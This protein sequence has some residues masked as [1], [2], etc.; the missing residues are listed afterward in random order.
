[1]GSQLACFAPIQLY[2]FDIT[3]KCKDLSHPQ[4]VLILPQW[5]LF[6]K[7]PFAFVNR[8]LTSWSVAPSI[9][10]ALPKRRVLVILLIILYL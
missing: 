2:P 7:V 5:A 10:T 6:Y 4:Y 8:I 9:V 3:I 1:V